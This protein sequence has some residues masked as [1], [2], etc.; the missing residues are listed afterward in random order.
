M[1]LTSSNHSINHMDHMGL[2]GEPVGSSHEVGNDFFL[3]TA[4]SRGRVPVLE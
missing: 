2:L 4:V 1:F 3:K